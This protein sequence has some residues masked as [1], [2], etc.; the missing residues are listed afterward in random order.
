M[1]CQVS[2]GLSVIITAVPLVKRALPE[3]ERYSEGVRNC[4]LPNEVHAGSKIKT[5]SQAMCLIACQL[6]WLQTNESCVPWDNVPFSSRGIHYNFGT[7]VLELMINYVQ[8]S[9]YAVD[10][11]L[12]GSETSF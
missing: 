9:E 2:A 8:S 12:R 11:R 7:L 10:M 3:A 4:R 6:E 5:Y 1:S